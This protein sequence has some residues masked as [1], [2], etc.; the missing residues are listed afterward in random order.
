MRSPL[1][2]ENRLS[3]SLRTKIEALE[4]PV[5]KT[6][7]PA[8]SAEGYKFKLEAIGEAPIPE[9]AVT[10]VTTDKEGNAKF[11]LKYGI[12]DYQAYLGEGDTPT[13]FVYKVSEV[14][15][16]PKTGI[17]YDETVYTVTVTFKASDPV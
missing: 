6:V 15:E 11:E 3:S 5:H 2:Q 10:E 8:G 16:N 4:I 7:K 12:A 13:P 9:G 1:S 17:T 14:R